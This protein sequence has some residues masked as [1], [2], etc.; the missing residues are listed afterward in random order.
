MNGFSKF[1]LIAAIAVALLFV[2][3]YH[4]NAVAPGPPVSQDRNKHNLSSDVYDVVRAVSA[5]PDSQDV[6]VP[7]ASPTPLIRPGRDSSI[8]YKAQSDTTKTS[9][10]QICIF[11]HTPHNAN[12]VNQAPL[13]NRKFS[14]QTFS[15]YSSHTLQIRVNPAISSS[16]QY[17]AGT[18]PDGSSKLCLSCHDGVSKLGEVIRGGP[19]AMAVSGGDVITGL[20]SFNPSTNKMKTGHHPVSFVYNGTVQQAIS[21]ARVTLGFQLPTAVPQVK[22]DKNQKMQCTTCHN[23]HQNQSDDDL[24]YDTGDSNNPKA[25]YSTP[26]ATRKVVP[27]WVYGVSGNA[28]NDHDTVCNSCHDMRPKPSWP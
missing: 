13:W 3:T 2:R 17:T 24:C 18:Q 16:A 6:N 14:S 11:C 26:T 21:S 25:C 7:I 27:F 5:F 1:K 19:I 23:P 4:V 10:R 20:A 15:R 22:L 9:G 12:V 8:K 28:S